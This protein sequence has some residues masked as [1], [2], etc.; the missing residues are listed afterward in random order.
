MEPDKRNALIGQ[1]KFFPKG[2]KKL[3][4]Y[5]YGALCESLIDLYDMRIWVDVIPLRAILNVKN[6]RYTNIGWVDGT[7]WVFKQAAR[8]CYFVDFELA[9]KNRMRIFKNYHFDAY[10]IGSKEDSMTYLP[11]STLQQIF[12]RGLEYPFRCRPVYL[13]GVWGGYYVKRLRHLPKSM[14]NCA[15]VFDMIPMEVSTVFKIGDTEY[16]FPF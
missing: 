10:I 5:G 12:R 3:I 7:E 8:R 2:K 14:K 1:I 9:M 6:G 13:E 11:V 4:I 16:E 15:W